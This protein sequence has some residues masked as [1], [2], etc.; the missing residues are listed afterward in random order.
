M[1]VRNDNRCLLFFIIAFLLSLQCVILV[2]LIFSFH[3][4]SSHI[5][6]LNPSTSVY[7]PKYDLFLYD[8]LLV[9]CGGFYALLCVYDR[10]RRKHGHYG[11]WVRAEVF[12]VSLQVF[13]VLKMV[14]DD[15]KNGFF[16]YF[17]CGALSASFVSKILWPRR[18][19]VDVF[20]AGMFQRTYHT[21]ALAFRKIRMWTRFLPIRRRSRPVMPKASPCISWLLNAGTIV[22]IALLIYVPDLEALVGKIFLSEIAQREN[23]SF[24]V[25]TAYAVFT[26]LIP[27]VDVRSLYGVGLPVFWG[28]LMGLWGHFDYI[29]F[30]RAV[31]G[32]F[33]VYYC[34][35]F[36]LIRSWVKSTM[37]GITLILL[38]VNLNIFG[39]EN[40][41]SLVFVSFNTT[42]VRFGLDIL[43]FVWINLHL[44][45][46][47]SVFLL[48]AGI[49]TGIQLFYVMPTGLC[50][51][52]LFYGYSVILLAV[53]ALRARFF[54]RDRDYSLLKAACFLVPGLF[55][56]LMA[57][58]VG[59]NIL[60][61]A[62]WYNFFEQTR[63]A[64]NG[65][66]LSPYFSLW[67]GYP[68]LFCMSWGILVIFLAS[69]VLVLT[70]IGR[71]GLGDRRL[72]IIVLLS[73]YGLMDY[74]QFIMLAT[75]SVLLRNVKLLVIV[76]GLWMDIFLERKPAVWRFYITAAALA[77]VL[78]SIGG[79]L[80]FRTY[81]NI[82]NLS[83]NPN[84]DPRFPSCINT[85]SR[86]FPEW[87][88]LPVNSL[89][90]KFEDLRT[91]K[92]FRSDDELKKYARQE[93][94]FDKDAQLIRALTPE[95]SRVA[96]ISSQ[97]TLFLI[98]ARRKPFFYVFPLIASRPMRMRTYLVDEF[99]S[100]ENFFKTIDQLENLKP[101]YIFV[102]KVL[103]N[104]VV[105]SG[106]FFDY[107][108]IV[109]L[110]MYVWGRYEPYQDGYYLMA[111]KRR[112]KK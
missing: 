54:V 35:W 39:V 97:E 77:I 84:V 43:W 99:F 51:T 25:G 18:T 30:T 23:S 1:A 108:G 42:A 53:P 57:L 82:F 80:R 45:T 104:R 63:L 31:M 29:T 50:L 95:G 94:N 48:L 47:R 79:N 6:F 9:L 59:S 110:M 90:Q 10:S 66:P 21:T 12:W 20:L 112:D 83:R 19:W 8:L 33:I 41:F 7:K 89:G 22:F 91:E 4:L 36:L 44:K 46:A 2:G 70:D 107:Q 72:M 52:V 93:F 103:L 61:H 85:F 78:F 3:P 100:K 87:Y 73:L 81:P 75:P 69:F 17:L 24:V 98:Q 16:F 101:Q 109:N 56:G 28:K 60:S 106:Y 58:C 67:K 74:Q 105:P 64:A 55:F 76:T 86:N 5:E 102:Q 111:M 34:A 13:A 88:K 26:G 27:C 62:F 11:A 14:S 68:F 96:V 65:F 38:I 49:T 71:Q 15:Q 40:P 92:D 37:L 32:L